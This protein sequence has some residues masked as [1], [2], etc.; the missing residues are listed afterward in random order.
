MT[1]S[2]GQG[3]RFLLAVIDGGG[4]VPPTLG[5]A[6]ALVRRGHQVRVLADPTV[7]PAARAAGCAFTPWRAAPH[8]DS[9]A[10]QTAL[11]G[12]MEARN[13]LGQ[14]RAARDLLICGPA[15]R[16]AA[17]VLTTLDEHPADAIL[18]DAAIPGILIGAE[19]AGLPTAALMANIY[20]RPTPGLPVF[21]TGW[22]PAKG[23]LGRIRDRLAV[24]AFGRIWSKSLPG[25]NDLRRSYGLPA[26]G[27]LYEVLDPCQRVLVM[28][29]PSFDFAAP[30]LPSNVRY[31][32]PQLDDPDWASSTGWTP[33]PGADPL[34]LV[35]MSSVYQNQLRVLRRIAAA[36]G[37]LPV[38]AV[39]TTGRA[40]DPAQIEA[41]GNVTVVESAP[42]QAILPEAAVVITHAGHGT[43]IKALAAGVP[44]V[45]MPMGRDQHDNTTRV[46]RLGAGVR[47]RKGAGPDRIAAAVRR[48]LDQPDYA[49]AAGRFAATLGHETETRPTAI[50][51]AEN[52]L[53]GRRGRSADPG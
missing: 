6:A 5:L 44:L 37:G 25:L 23:P 22:R 40:V 3:A 53:S 27:E 43:V 26:L 34:V 9:L 45:C 20:L 11:I 8:F 2:P 47:V 49:R 14:F 35:A 32:G 12:S 4:T 21:G 15:D 39:I 13:P 17:D 38:R 42:H 19:A 30:Q 31:V 51:E 1:T 52:L 16:F 33:P 29:S 28:T 10:E 36:L 24:S 41:A 48:V 18:A 46:L 50:D 7:E